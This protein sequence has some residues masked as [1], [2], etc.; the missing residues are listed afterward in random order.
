MSDIQNR[1]CIWKRETTYAGWLV[2]VK[3]NKGW[4]KCK[5]HIYRTT[6]GRQ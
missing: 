1:E 6:D 2:S 4:L 3:M 5:K